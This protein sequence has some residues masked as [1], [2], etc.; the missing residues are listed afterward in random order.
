MNNQIRDLLFWV[1]PTVGRDLR[2]LHLSKE[3]LK[4]KN[5]I[6]PSF[7]THLRNLAH[8]KHTVQHCSILHIFEYVMRPC[9]FQYK[10]C[11]FQVDTQLV[12]TV[13]LDNHM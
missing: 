12:S 10:Y 9:G 8:T 2:A 7:A 1:K 11:V 13:I 5:V 6:S 4:L 3:L